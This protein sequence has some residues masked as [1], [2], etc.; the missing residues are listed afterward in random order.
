[1]SIQTKRVI[2]IKVK[3]KRK[4]VFKHRINSK[5]KKVRKLVPHRRKRKPHDDKVKYNESFNMAYNEGFDAGYA[6]GLG[7]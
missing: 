3:K 6:K 7:A 2:K 5:V 1:M 4:I